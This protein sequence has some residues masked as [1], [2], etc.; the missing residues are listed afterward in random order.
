M[1]KIIHYLDLVMGAFQLVFQR[2]IA[3]LLITKQLFIH[4][5]G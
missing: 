2:L 1:L 4:I 5:K 3:L